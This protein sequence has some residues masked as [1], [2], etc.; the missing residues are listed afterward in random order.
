M[1][2]N[3]TELT[4]RYNE[5]DRMGIVHHSN[6]YN[7]FEVGRGKYIFKAGFSYADMEKMGIMMPLIETHCR[8]HIGAKYLDDIIIKTKIKQLNGI[9]V[10]FEYSAIRKADN[11]L[12]ANGSTLH[13]FINNDFK[14]INIQK[15]FPDIWAK[16]IEL[17]E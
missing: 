13:A 9:K 15:K 16:I 14:I 1:Y 8:Y 17:Y 3:E 12:L 5:T 10:T 7:W 2:I 4:V 6:Y 11:V